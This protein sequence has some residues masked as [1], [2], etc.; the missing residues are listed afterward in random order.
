MSPTIKGEGVEF[1]PSMPMGGEN[2]CLLSGDSRWRRH[3]VVS[4]VG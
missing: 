1:D 3:V 2:L 4:P